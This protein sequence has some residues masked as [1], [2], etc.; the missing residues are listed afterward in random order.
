MGEQE[1]VERSPFINTRCRL[2]RLKDAKFFAG[3]VRDLTA[4]ELHLRLSTRT[5]LMDGDTFS[6][7]VHGTDR[8]AVFNAWLTSQNEDEVVFEI[9]EQIRYM[10]SRERARLRVEGV[11]GTFRHDGVETPFTVNDISLEGCGIVV[12]HPIS[13]GVKLELQVETPQGPIACPGEV[14][15]SKPDPDIP[16]AFRLGIQLEG[17]GRLE[18]AR[19]ARMFEFYLAA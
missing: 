10:P 18:A 12:P 6:V 5:S 13:R 4:T 16:G 2:Q 15:Y 8:S 14:R 1:Q 3:W 19:W 7:E 11:T 9:H 17:L